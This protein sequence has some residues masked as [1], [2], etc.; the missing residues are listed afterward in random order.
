MFIKIYTLN[1]AWPV[2]GEDKFF[3][4]H[5]IMLLVWYLHNYSNEYSDDFSSF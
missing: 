5:F 3:A 2:N 1:I 4:V